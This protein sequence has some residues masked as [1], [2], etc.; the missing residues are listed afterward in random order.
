MSQSIVD[1]WVDDI[2]FTFEV[3]RYCLNVVRTSSLLLVF[4]R[5]VFDSTKQTAEAKG[6]IAGTFTYVRRDGIVIDPGS[7]LEVIF[8]PVSH[9]ALKNLGHCCAQFAGYLQHQLARH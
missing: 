5:S 1:R 2:A 4:A 3:P 7:S 8:Q 6:L 9:Q